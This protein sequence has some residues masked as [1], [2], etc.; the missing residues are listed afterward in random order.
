VRGCLAENRHVVFFWK[1][2]ENKTTTTKKNKQIY[3]ILLE[4]MLERRHDI[5]KGYKYTPTDSMVLVHLATL[6]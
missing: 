1:L 4:W 6:S 5:W 3:D 2:P